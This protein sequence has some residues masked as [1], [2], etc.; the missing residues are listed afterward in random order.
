ML[1]CTV[2]SPNGVGDDVDGEL[3]LNGTTALQQVQRLLSQLRPLRQALSEK[4]PVST[5]SQPV[6][7][8]GTSLRMF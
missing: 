6:Q 4:R 2:K 8:H 1:K 3:F 5:F 7:S